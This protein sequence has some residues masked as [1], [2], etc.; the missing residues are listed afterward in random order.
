LLRCCPRGLWDIYVLPAEESV[1]Q[2]RISTPFPPLLEENPLELHSWC[3]R[4]S[5]NLA[6]VMAFC[7]GWNIEEGQPFSVSGVI[8]HLNE[9]NVLR[10]TEG[11]SFF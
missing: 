10:N 5:L 2:A 8:G 1:L 11:A 4:T 6:I 9:A 3:L 7:V